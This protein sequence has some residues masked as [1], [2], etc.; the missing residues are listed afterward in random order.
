MLWPRAYVAVIAISWAID[1]I[2]FQALGIRNGR[3]GGGEDDFAII[4]EALNIVAHH[5]LQTPSPSQPSIFRQSVCMGV[6]VLR[7]LHNFQET[8]T[9]ITS[10][11]VIVFNTLRTSGIRGTKSGSLLLR[12]TRTMTATPAC[13]KFC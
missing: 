5:L 4:A 6:F 12:D 10:P 13:C 7:R 9:S 11:G 8:P 1:R 2:F 3:V